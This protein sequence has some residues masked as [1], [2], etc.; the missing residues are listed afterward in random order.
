MLHLDE[1]TRN[2]WLAHWMELATE[3]LEQQ[4][5]RSPKPGRYSFGDQVTI[6]DL[7]L[8]PHVTTAFM[9]YDFDLQRYPLTD[10]IYRACME[11]AAFSATHPDTQPG[12]G[13]PH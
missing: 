1:A 3:L 7:C 5:E 2:A 12:A 8:V 6:A 10:R 4:L 11:L 9:L 13:Q